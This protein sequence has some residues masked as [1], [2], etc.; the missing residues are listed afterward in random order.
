RH[1]NHPCPPLLLVTDRRQA[2]QSLSNIV[3]EACAAGCRWISLREKDLSD[4]EQVALLC[5]LQP[6]A[7]QWGARMTIHGSARSARAA[8]ADGVH[9]MAGCDPA[10]ARALLG[11][12]ALIGLS[13]HRVAEMDGLTSDA[14]DYVIAGPAYETES[15]PGYGP[16]L[17]AA[18]VAAIAAQSDIPVIA[19]G[20]IMPEH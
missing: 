10:P 6:I 13:V 3:N 12:Q 18:G 8:K 5:K 14:L 19:I 2:R 7:R 4:D 17:G 1:V 9:L 11:D 20:G 15:K 16:V